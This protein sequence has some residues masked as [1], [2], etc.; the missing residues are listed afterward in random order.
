MNLDQFITKYS[1]KYVEFHSYSNNS[2]WQCVDICNQWLVEGLKLSAIIG[3]NAMDFPKK[4]SNELSYIKNTIEAFPE[5]GDLVIFSSSDGV[6]HISIFVKSIHQNLFTSFDQNY[7][8]GSPCKLVNH[9]Y[10]NVLGWL[11][12][13]GES[14]PDDGTQDMQEK[15]AWYEKEYPLEQQRVRDARSE[16]DDLAREIER[17]IDAHEK[18]TQ[19]IEALLAGAK[20]EARQQKDAFDDHKSWEAA[21][22]DT[23]EDIPQIRAKI[24]ELITI[25]DQKKRIE[26]ELGFTQNELARMETRNAKLDTEIEALRDEL[27][28]AK[29][30][31]DAKTAEL[32]SE[33][34]SR[35]LRIKRLINQ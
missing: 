14:M 11:R 10:K 19:E 32:L 8:T 34:L 17:L 27:K 26:K 15:L 31:K 6:G 24:T 12:P 5:P 1:G 3:T 20:E 7:P 2:L 16:R 21:A 30:L 23:P 22:L 33:L 13:K 35:L 28:V 18:E 4:A 9:S 29:G 25:E